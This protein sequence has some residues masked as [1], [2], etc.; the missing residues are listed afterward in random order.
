MNRARTLTGLFTR[1]TR[2][3]P[4]GWALLIAG[5]ALIVAAY[6]LGRSEPLYLG[7][8]LA[9]APLIALATVRLRRMRIHTSRRFTPH[10]AS[11]H[12]PLDVT[13]EIRNRAPSRTVRARWR[14]TLPFASGTAAGI[15]PP[16]APYRSSRSTGTTATIDYRVVPPRRGVVDIGPL[17][18]DFP[19]PFGLAFG[20]VAVGETHS[21]IVTPAV[22][23]LPDTGRSIAADDGT[24]RAHQQRSSPNEDELMT[25]EYRAGDPLRR[26]HWKASARHGELMVRQEEQRSHARA[27]LILDTRHGGYRDVQ[28]AT[29]TEP[30]SDSFEWLVAFTASLT[31]RLQQ[32]GYSVDITETAWPQLASADVRD[33]LLESLA[34]VELR[35]EPRRSLG[36]R[37]EPGRTLGTLIVLLSEAEPH[38][39]DELV[40]HRV[41]YDRAFAFIVAARRD[42]VA[43][44]LAAAGFACIEL[45]P[46][47]DPVDVWLTIAHLND[48]AV[49]DG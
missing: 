38:I 42:A 32:S 20:E 23:A 25:R 49:V 1:R 11:A 9:A 41:H 17:V 46:D 31:L 47:D 18:I 10:L 22:T 34:T 12:L 14:D 35:D 4:R 15:L 43:E 40:A 6:S 3:T 37:P 5:A 24:A 2:P 27:H 48:P 33:E 30:A 36:L 13:V 8:F 7:V 26:V 19:D 44:P 39:V 28:R 16:L 29:P 45:F 21:I